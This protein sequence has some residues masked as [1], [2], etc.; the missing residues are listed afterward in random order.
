MVPYPSQ[1]LRLSPQSLFVWISLFGRIPVTVRRDELDL[2]RGFMLDRRSIPPGP[3]ILLVFPM[4]EGLIAQS[5]DP[6]RLDN[7]SI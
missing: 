6:G 5:D 3:P 4:V 2:F 1:A 7:S